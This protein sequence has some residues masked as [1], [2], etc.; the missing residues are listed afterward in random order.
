[1]GGKQPRKQL[2]TKQARKQT[3]AYWTSG[4]AEAREEGRTK[5]REEALAKARKEARAKLR[6][7]PI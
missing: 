6:P 4:G 5:A 2:A 3:K 7:R 1:M